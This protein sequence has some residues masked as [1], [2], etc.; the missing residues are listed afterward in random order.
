[1]ELEG[2]YAFIHVC[3]FVG[4][5]VS[6]II[7]NDMDGFGQNFHLCDKDLLDFGEDRAIK[8][9]QCSNLHSAKVFSK[10]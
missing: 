6:R 3:L 8:F 10:H 2:G 5:F 7:H 4:L 9:P 1:M